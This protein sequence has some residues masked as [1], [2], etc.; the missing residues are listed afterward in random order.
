MLKKHSIVNWC[1]LSNVLTHFGFRDSIFHAIM[2]LYTSP[3][4][5]VFALG[6]LSSPFNITDG[7]PEG[8]PLSLLVFAL[9]IEPLAAY[10]RSSSDISGISVGSVEHKIG[11]Y[12][13]DIVLICSSPSDSLTALLK[14]P[15]EYSLVSYYKLNKTKSIVLP[16]SNSPT[17]QSS[18]ASFNFHWATSHLP[19]LGIDLTLSPTRIVEHFLNNYLPKL[20]NKLNAYPPSLY[21]GWHA[22]TCVKFYC[23][24]DSFMLFVPYYI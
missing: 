23:Y 19:Y 10:I 7:T 5:S 4:M 3:S 17:L 18:F 22:L 12:V 24:P 21:H 16:L 9:C 15:D 8:C 2:S 14:I 6:F 11:L 20:K 1:Y 13:D